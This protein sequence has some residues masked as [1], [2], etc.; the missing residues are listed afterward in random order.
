[1][2]DKPQFRLDLCNELIYICFV[3]I[4]FITGIKLRIIKIKLQL[5]REN[6]HFFTESVLSISNR[7]LQ[8]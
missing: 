8:N 1:M 5:K 4:T 3:S 6:N 2:I 7:N